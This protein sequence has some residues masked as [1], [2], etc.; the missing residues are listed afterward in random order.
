MYEFNDFYGNTEI[1]NENMFDNIDMFKRIGF[2]K[3]LFSMIL[4]FIVEMLLSE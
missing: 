1:I 3:P 2:I 4:D